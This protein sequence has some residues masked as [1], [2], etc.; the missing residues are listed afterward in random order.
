M[1]ENALYREKKNSASPQWKMRSESIES[2]NAIG[3]KVKQ[4][5]V[6]FQ[7]RIPSTGERR[8]SDVSC[9]LVQ[10]Q[11]GTVSA[12]D[13]LPGPFISMESQVHAAFQALTCHMP[14]R[15]LN[16]CLASSPR[17]PNAY[18]TTNTRS[19]EPNFAHLV[20]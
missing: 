6:S 9:S 4:L 3:P 2:L 7:C 13:F 11:R 1:R 12:K 20:S 5:S 15:S 8:T 10:S 19:S 17:H 16:K 14:T 18:Q